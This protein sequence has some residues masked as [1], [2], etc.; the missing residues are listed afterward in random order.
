MRGR[1]S[2]KKVYYLKDLDCAACSAKIEKALNT[3]DEIDLCTLDFINKKLY[4]ETEHEWRSEDELIAF[5]EKTIHIFESEVYIQKLEEMEE[6]KEEK[7]PL[8]KR[9]WF[10]LIFPALAL[11][12]L[13]LGFVIKN[14]IA[15]IILYCVGYVA[16][17][18]DVVYKCVKKLIR[19]GIFD[20]NVLMV[21]ATIGALALQEY[22][23]AIMVM[24]LYKIGEAFQDYALGKSKK[25]LEKML[26]LRPEYAN[27]IRGG[28]EHQ[29]RPEKLKVGDLVVVKNGEKIPTDGKVVNGSTFI[30]NSMLTGESKQQRVTIGS[31]VYSG[32]IN[33]SSVIT[34]KVTKVYQN[35]AISKVLQLVQDASA[36]KPKAE[37]FITKFARIY[38]PAVFGCALVLFLIPSVITGEYAVWLYRSLTF[39]VVSCPCAIVI[40]VPL[41]FFSGVGRCAKY[42][43]LIKGASFMDTLHEIDTIVFDKTGTLTKGDFKVQEI[44]PKDISK[45]SFV[46]FLCYAESSSNHPI[47]K[48]VSH[49]YSGKIFQSKIGSLEEIAGKG[50]KATIEGKEVLCGRASFLQENNIDIEKVESAGSVVYMAIDQ[51]YVGY[52][53]ISDTIKEET[54]NAISQLREM[55]IKN[56]VMLTGDKKEIADWVG[57]SLGFTKVYAELMP[58]EKLEKLQEIKK[59]AK[60]IMYVGDGINDAP[61][62]STCDIGVAMGGGSDIAVEIGD[63]VLM[64][65]NLISLVS[66]LKIAKATHSTYIQNIVFALGV[67]L[68]AMLLGVVG[69]TNLWIAVFADVGVSILAILNSMRLLYFR[70]HN[71]CKS[72]EEKHP[73]TNCLTGGCDIK[74]TAK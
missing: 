23:E 66:S 41:A 37:K 56:I 12:F 62:L 30:D 9:W 68:V 64:N 17:G 52:I 45:E 20:E 53:V 51:K 4:I 39:L 46:K 49:L 47:A 33:M 8:C 25:S 15:S 73:H 48:S 7:E 31:K 27:V 29:V 65:G 58:E 54:K 36:N 2:M 71:R 61:V 63:I 32:T 19:G 43:V 13:I 72:C 44:C 67:K 55:G 28:E 16:V 74:T 42:G 11:V 14:E 40:S 60:K 3:F 34:V 70:P 5:L 24:L 57:N 59:N 35:S 26:T 38:T 18:Y 22:P 10:K 21:V 1:S 69:L 50:I 6:E